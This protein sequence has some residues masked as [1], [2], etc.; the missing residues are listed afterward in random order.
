MIYL[1]AIL[2]GVS[3]QPEAVLDEFDLVEVN[4]LY[5]EYGGHQLDQLVF[6]NFDRSDRQLKCEAWAILR[7]CRSHPTK[8]DEEKFNEYRDKVIEILF[9]DPIDKQKARQ[10]IKVKG[11]YIGGPNT[12]RK[13]GDGYLTQF[14]SHGVLRRVYTKAMIETHTNIDPERANADKFKDYQRLGFSQKG[15]WHGNGED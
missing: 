15:D 3:G 4:H 9:K 14:T 8:E 11:E 12:P 1:L 6:Y 7:N 13:Y 5:N 2:L 10:Y